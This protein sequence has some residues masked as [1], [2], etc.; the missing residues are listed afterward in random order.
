MMKLPV[1]ARFASHFLWWALYIF[2]VT[3]ILTHWVAVA[4]TTS[5]VTV[6]NRL[7]QPSHLINDSSTV[8]QLAVQKF[9]TAVNEQSESE[10]RAFFYTDSFIGNNNDNHADGSST[11][12]GYIDNSTIAGPEP[13]HQ[14]NLY[15]WSGGVSLTLDLDAYQKSLRYLNPSETVYL[16]D[17]LF[18][19]GR[20]QIVNI[21]LLSESALRE[22]FDRQQSMA[23]RDK[24]SWLILHSPYSGSTTEIRYVIVAR[25]IT[26]R[27]NPQSVNYQF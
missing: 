12:S 3:G 1:I 17:E 5:A 24:F 6:L 21:M 19:P 2:I 15:R 7:S 10:A 27:F 4:N 11:T 20:Y 16:Q 14:S 26:S 13:M 8:A 18:G 23:E 22:W 25:K 9:A